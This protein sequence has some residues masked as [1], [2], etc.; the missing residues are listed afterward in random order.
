[1]TMILTFYYWNFYLKN[2]W[3]SLPIYISPFFTEYW[4]SFLIIL[5]Y[6]FPSYRQYLF[7]VIFIHIL[8]HLYHGSLDIFTSLVCYL[9][10][11]FCKYMLIKAVN[12]VYN[13]WNRVYNLKNLLIWQFLS[14]YCKNTVF[15]IDMLEVC[16]IS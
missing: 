16:M 7:S 6:L 3:N 1:M 9:W 12:N 8:K 10:K 14:F 13:M 11:H 5:S 2:P 15:H 4:F